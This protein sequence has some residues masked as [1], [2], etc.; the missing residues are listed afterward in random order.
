MTFTKDENKL[1]TASDDK[2]LAL[3]DLNESRVASRFEGHED[4]VTCVKNHFRN[5]N[6]F[7]SCSTD[8]MVMLWDCRVKNSVGTMM[9]GGVM[10][11]GA[12]G[13]MPVGRGRIWHTADIELIFY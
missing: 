10:D 1:L 9:R 6:C 11:I 2:T 8:K 5:E 4:K 12:R 13:E 7:Y 3:V